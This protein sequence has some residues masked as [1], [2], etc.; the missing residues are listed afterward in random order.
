MISKITVLQIMF[1][2]LLPGIIWAQTY[3]IN[4]SG[5]GDCGTGGIDGPYNCVFDGD[6]PEILGSFT[7]TNVPDAELTALS[8][9]LYNACNGN[10]ELFLNGVALGTG[11]TTGTNCECET[12][13][14]NPSVS[15]NIAITLSQEIQEAYMMGG[16]NELSVAVSNSVFDGLQCFYGAELTATTETLST[17]TLLHTAAQV[18]PNPVNNQLTITGISSQK[19]YDIYTLQG[20]LVLSGTLQQESAIDVALLAPGSYLLLVEDTRALPFMKL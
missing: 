6:P 10:F 8:V 1:F 15:N 4:A 2:I 16:S 9:L 7:D 11:A 5:S 18:Y 3:T 17:N 13:A 19:S 12:I 14:S 20:Q